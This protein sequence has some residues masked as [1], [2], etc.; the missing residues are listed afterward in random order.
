M[1]SSSFRLAGRV[2]ADANRDVLDI[3][4]GSGDDR[5]REIDLICSTLEQLVDLQLLAG[6]DPVLT[7][8]VLGALGRRSRPRSAG[9]CRAEVLA[10]IDEALQEVRD[11]AEYLAET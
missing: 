11:R 9:M 2:A 7:R 8:Q 6:R 10:M 3:P 4:A 5:G 1:R